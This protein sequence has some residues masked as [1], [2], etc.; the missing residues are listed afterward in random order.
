MRSKGTGGAE[1]R[2]M[3]GWGDATLGG[4]CLIYIPNRGSLEGEFEERADNAQGRASAGKTVV[5]DIITVSVS[6]VKRLNSETEQDPAR[7]PFNG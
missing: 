3:S 1:E 5:S 2:V 7:V 4:G 6:C